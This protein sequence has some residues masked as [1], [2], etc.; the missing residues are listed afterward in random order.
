MLAVGDDHVQRDPP[1]RRG[2]EIRHQEGGQSV[3]PGGDGLQGT[4][5]AR[6]LYGDLRVFQQ[7][8]LVIPDDEPELLGGQRDHAEIHAVPRIDMGLFFVGQGFGLGQQLFLGLL[9][10]G[11]VRRV[12]GL[13]HVKE[14]QLVGI[15]RF[16]VLLIVTNHGADDGLHFRHIFPYLVGQAAFF[17]LGQLGVRLQLV[18]AVE[19]GQPPCFQPIPV[20]IQLIPELAQQVFDPFQRLIAQQLGFIPDAH[21]QTADLVGKQPFQILLNLQRV[22]GRGRLHASLPALKL[23]L[24]GDQLPG[25]GDFLLRQKR[26]LSQRRKLHGQQNQGRQQAEHTLQLFHLWDSS[27]SSAGVKMGRRNGKK[28][29]LVIKAV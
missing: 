13:Q 20:M 17:P 10:D 29:S 6:R 11:A 16:F 2:N 3:F 14:V 15:D 23:A 21:K 22:H 8:A 9:G 4:G 18:Q 26:L 7:L 27:C 25:F 5:I 24:H 28:R 1:V 12:R 19:Y